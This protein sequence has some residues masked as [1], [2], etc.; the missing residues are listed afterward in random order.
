MLN[1]KL[2]LNDYLLQALD[3]AL[4]LAD[5]ERGQV[6]KELAKDIDDFLATGGGTLGNIISQKHQIKTLKG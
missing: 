3:S 6:F 4:S 5:K 2:N 1:P